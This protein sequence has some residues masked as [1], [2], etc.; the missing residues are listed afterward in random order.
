MKATLATLLAIVAF[1][2]FA[3][4]AR[5]A[6]NAVV[7]FMPVNSSVQTGD[8]ISVDVTVANV[9]ADPGLAQYDLT[10]H[11]DPA[12]VR[13]ENL[14]DSGFITTGQT[15]VVCVPG[16]IDNAAGTAVSTCTPVPLFGL[17]GVSTAPAVVLL[18]ASL[19][20]LAAGTS[21]LTLSG[22]LAGPTGTIIPATFERGS[23]NVS[24]PAPAA[25][26]TARPSASLTPAPSPTVIAATP[27]SVSTPRSQPTAAANT[28]APAAQTA[29]APLKVPPTG[30]GGSGV[31]Y[32]W[33]ALVVA[34]LA[35]GGLGACSYAF[36]RHRRLR[37]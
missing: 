35:L 9:D 10:I 7:T 36:W 14:T 25:S 21:Q 3:A 5:A 23:I 30:S 26:P 2:G 16:T 15:I 1:A 29:A 20:A 4:P 22:T 12:L 6:G 28:P 27:T 33:T 17:P 13:I 37:D 11:V 19:T 32:S 8:V 24:A 31:G 34:I 18:H